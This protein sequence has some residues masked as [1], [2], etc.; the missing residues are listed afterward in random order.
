MMKKVCISTLIATLAVEIT[1]VIVNL[2]S[3]AVSGNFLL[4]MT[5]QGGEWIGQSGFG[6]LLNRTYPMSTPDHPVSGSEWISFDLS[7][8]IL[9][10]VICLI[11]FSLVFFIIFKVKA[12]DRVRELERC[13]DDE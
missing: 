13:D 6:L 2:I 9:T 5:I 7:G 10:L 8:L 4:A 1:G 3:Y 12:A 11:I